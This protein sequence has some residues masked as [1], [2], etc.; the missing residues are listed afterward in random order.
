MKMMITNQNL[1]IPIHLNNDI[2]T[3]SSTPT[4]NERDG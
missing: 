3:V 4:K 1:I 2:T